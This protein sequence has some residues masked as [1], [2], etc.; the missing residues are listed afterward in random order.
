MK[1]LVQSS[2]FLTKRGSSLQQYFTKQQCAFSTIT[3]LLKEDETGKV[4]TKPI[5]KQTPVEQQVL[6][7]LKYNSEGKVAEAVDSYEQLK[8]MTKDIDL[9]TLNAIIS[10]F[11]PK[12]L[13]FKWYK[14]YKDYV[15]M[16]TEASKFRAKERVAEA[17]RVFQDISQYHPSPDIISYNALMKVQLS[18]DEV[19]NV[20]DTFN[21]LQ[22]NTGVTQTKLYNDELLVT[23]GTL[24]R[25]C[26][27]LEQVGLAEEIYFFALQEIIK[28]RLAN[29]H[30][31]PWRSSESVSYLTFFNTMLDVYSESRDPFAFK[32][33]EQMIAN[34]SGAHYA[35]KQFSSEGKQRYKRN[36]RLLGSLNG[37]TFNNYAKACIF[38]DQRVRLVEMVERMR[39]EG[40]LQ[41]E[42]SKP[43]R[44]EIKHALET[45]TEQFY[46][47]HRSELLPEGLHDRIATDYFADLRDFM[48][49]D[50]DDEAN[51]A[52]GREVD[53]RDFKFMKYLKPTHDMYRIELSDAFRETVSA[54]KVPFL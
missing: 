2:T 40:V 53:T 47:K 20:F 28:D 18:A 39:V 51:L 8:K 11:A 17:K 1:R 44:D 15:D 6:K 38:M 27:M 49:I 52:W 31:K 3:K 35:N 36:P 43:V 4:P 12:K 25:A 32:F 10:S 22:T 16:Y 21:E 42:L 46:K 13:L 48:I 5:Q 26:S 29:S 30:E 37:V 50:T 41:S 9:K 33:F 7:I 19:L 54:P 23:F 24:L 14:P 45:Y 34:S